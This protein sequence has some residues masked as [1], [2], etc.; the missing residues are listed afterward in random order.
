[1]LAGVALA[2]QIVHGQ[3]TAATVV[4]GAVAANVVVPSLARLG[5]ELVEATAG[6]LAS[7]T[8][9]VSPANLVTKETFPDCRE[10]FSALVVRSIGAPEIGV[11]NKVD[12]F[13]PASTVRQIPRAS[14]RAPLGV[15]AEMVASSM[16]P[17]CSLQIAKTELVPSLNLAVH[18]PL[19][20]LL[21]PAAVYPMSNFA[22][23][24]IA[25]S[26]CASVYRFP[27]RHI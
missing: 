25:T 5:N 19:A 11:R 7:L 14:M 26:R 22:T 1:M 15:A 6:D 16:I 4:T 17:G 13:P 12:P 27:Q 23:S 8:A 2:G 10:M 3:V 20:S 21:A 18:T 24:L 9:T